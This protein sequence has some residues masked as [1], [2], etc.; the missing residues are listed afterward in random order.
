M[1]FSR[2]GV[3]SLSHLISGLPS[4][5]HTTV[6]SSVMKLLHSIMMVHVLEFR[7][8]V[9]PSLSWACMF[10]F[11]CMIWPAS[12]QLT[13]FSDIWDCDSSWLLVG[14]NESSSTRFELSRDSGVKGNELISLMLNVLVSWPGESVSWGP[15]L[16]FLAFLTSMGHSLKKWSIAPWIWSYS[17][18]TNLVSLGLIYVSSGDWANTLAFWGVVRFWLSI[19]L[20]SVCGQLSAFSVVDRAF[21]LTVIAD[22]VYSESSEVFTV[23]NDLSVL[24]VWKNFVQNSSVFKLSWKSSSKSDTNPSKWN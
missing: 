13:E 3:G 18:L 24:N 4:V 19:S 22:P 12:N 11:C 2:Y 7:L 21:S 5:F 10:S 1:R 20:T 16:I 17:S 9:D 14:P 23:W 8:S 6:S 15:S